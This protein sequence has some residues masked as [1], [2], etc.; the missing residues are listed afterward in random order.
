MEI[1]VSGLSEFGLVKMIDGLQ[2]SVVCLDIAGG[3]CYLVAPKLKKVK[4]T[5]AEHSYPRFTVSGVDVDALYRAL[6]YYEYEQD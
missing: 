3:P 4:E 5:K 2:F 1:S 6:S